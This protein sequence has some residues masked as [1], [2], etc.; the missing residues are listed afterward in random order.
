[1]PLR[2]SGDFWSVDYQALS[3]YTFFDHPFIRIGMRNKSHFLEGNFQNNFD[4]LVCPKQLKNIIQQ[5]GPEKRRPPPLPLHTLISSLVF[6]V[7]QDSGTFAFNVKQLTAQQ[8]TD[9]ALSQRR[10]NIPWM[11][12]ETI[13]DCALS[14]KADR[15]KHPGAFYQERLW[16]GI[17]GSEFSV[18]NTPQNKKS[19]I[20][21]ASR[22]MKAAFGKVGVSVLTELGL[23]NPVAAMG[24]APGMS[25]QELS[26]PLLDKLPPKS[27]LLGDRA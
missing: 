23:H 14:A 16:M 18:R 5:F 10:G 8:I 9:S 3:A 21:A 11:V 26:R 20:K 4:Q 22:R 1:M 15:A 24:G 2:N 7:L 12:F 25:E 19:F 27:L 17:D 13:M 6:H